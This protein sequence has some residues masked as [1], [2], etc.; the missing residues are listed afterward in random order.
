MAPQITVPAA[1]VMAASIVLFVWVVVAIV[2]ELSY[3]RLL[4]LRP[5]AS[6]FKNAV[7]YVKA[8][9]ARAAAADRRN[10]L[11]SFLQQ[12]E[13]EGVVTREFLEVPPG[14]GDLPMRYFEGNRW[15]A[16]AHTAHLRWQL[17]DNRLL[18][19]ERVVDAIVYLQRLT[20]KLDDGDFSVTVR[21]GDVKRPG[22][23]NIFPW[24]VIVETSNPTPIAKHLSLVSDWLGIG[25][26]LVPA[27]EIQSLGI[28]RSGT[29][30]SNGQA[31]GLLSSQNDAH[32]EYGL[33]C[34]HVL[35]SA[36]G[37]LYCPTPPN[38]PEYG[39]YPNGALDA[40]LIELQSQCFVRGSESRTSIA[41]ATAGDRDRFIKT[42]QDVS[43]WPY[44]GGRK[45]ILETPVPAIRTKQGQIRAPHIQVLP[46]FTKRFGITWPII[47]RSFSTEGHSGAWVIDPMENLW[48]G[49][50]VHG[51]CPPVARSYALESAFLIDTFSRALPRERPFKPNLL[52]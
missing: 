19:T 5:F 3:R 31:A 17:S 43:K 48:F 34:H 36:C 15:S 38:R 4:G 42:G 8:D 46:K 41:C 29:D 11:L 25:V 47:G 21:L 33:V 45:G 39:D 9:K 14:F 24:R 23:I 6:T 2:S 28:C 27:T 37:S 50:I 51:T 18:L 32:R 7:P 12:V 10:H 22:K 44:L 52:S 20:P 49:M 13:S 40:A 35:S 1:G 16:A 30:G 26:D